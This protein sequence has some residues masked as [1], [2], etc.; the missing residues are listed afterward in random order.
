MPPSGSKVYTAQEIEELSRHL[1]PIFT[2]VIERVSEKILVPALD[3]QTQDIA[4]LMDAHEKDDDRRFEEITKNQSKTHEKL[5][6]I[7]ADLVEEKINKGI[8]H[9]I[10]YILVAVASALGPIVVAVID[11][12]LKKH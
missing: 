9:G 5:K 11:W 2:P 3:R 12:I 4:R 7:D 10:N 1:T 8:R 6:A